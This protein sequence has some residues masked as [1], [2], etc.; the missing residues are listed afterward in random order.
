[1]G[2]HRSYN[3][4]HT[5]KPIKSRCWEKLDLSASKKPELKVVLDANF[6]FIPSQFKLDIFEGLA[7]LLNQRFD[8]VFLSST[9]KELQ[10]LAHSGS[11]KVRNQAELGLRLA[12]RC[13][14]VSVEKRPMETYDDVI[15]RVAAEWRCAVATND[16]EVRKRLRVLGLPVIFLRQKHCLALDGSV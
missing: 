9:K 8:P 14:F 6:L 4:L 15:V 12:E 11:Q 5:K 10:G 16:R 3:Q 7:K 13:S 1:M 2:R